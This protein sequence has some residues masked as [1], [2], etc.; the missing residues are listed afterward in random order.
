MTGISA[1]RRRAAKLGYRFTKSNW[2]KD[3]IDNLGGYQ[4]VDIGR[5]TVVNGSRFDCSL[6]DV[7]AFL[8]REW[9]RRNGAAA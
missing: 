3:S 9:I 6:D 2:R 7:A 8:D 4:I 1:L 5:N